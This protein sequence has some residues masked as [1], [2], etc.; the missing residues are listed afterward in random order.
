[1]S[2]NTKTIF[3]YI[4]FDFLL[5]IKIEYIDLAPQSGHIWEPFGEEEESHCFDFISH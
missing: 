3:I 4:S 1:L 2:V 5:Y